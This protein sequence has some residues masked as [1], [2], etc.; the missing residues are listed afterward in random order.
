M[1]R[2]GELAP[3]I[4]VTKVMRSP[5]D[6]G[7]THDKL[8]GGLTVLEFYPHLLNSQMYRVHNQ[9]VERYA[10]ANV[11]FV[12][13]V[14]DEESKLQSWLDKHTL[15]GWLLLDANWDTVRAWGMR[16][17]QTAF[18]DAGG[19]LLGFS[20]FDE[21]TDRRI[22]E[23]AAG[24]IDSAHLRDQSDF[25]EILAPALPPSETVHIGPAQSESG[26][27]S[28]MAPD[29]WVML[30]FPLAELL[31]QAWGVHESV[32]DLPPGLDTGTRYDVRLVLP[33][34]VSQEAM[35]ARIQ[36]ALEQHFRL[37]VSREMRAVDVFVMTEPP[38]AVSSRTEIGELGWGVRAMPD[39]PFPMQRL[40]AIGKGFEGLGPVLRLSGGWVMVQ[41]SGS[42]GYSALDVTWLGSNTALM[43]AL[44]DELG[45]V[46]T[47][48]Q[49]EVL[50]IRRV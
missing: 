23:I 39:S 19:R 33:A 34:E 47:R 44:R 46:V 12:L 2:A 11:Q 15:N 27:T 6:T 14:R 36:R 18:V 45:I 38:E 35:A 20:R 43:P 50:T 32:L 30:G 49:V 40:S 25:H 41:N 10:G 48:E 26:T 9:R 16:L 4:T 7:W 37:E 3:E 13:I 42:E 28:A 1:S 17:P 29:Y 5:T 22:E 8:M 31:A 24:R 21:D